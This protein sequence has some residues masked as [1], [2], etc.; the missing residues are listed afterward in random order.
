MGPFPLRY[1]LWMPQD[2]IA[3]LVRQFNEEKS[4]FRWREVRICVEKLQASRKKAMT[5]RY[6]GGGAVVDIRGCIAVTGG[7]AGR[8]D[9][10]LRK[11]VQC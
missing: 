6:E 7:A 2:D 1:C 4:Q 11:V 10:I 9:A 5:T 3:S 8:E